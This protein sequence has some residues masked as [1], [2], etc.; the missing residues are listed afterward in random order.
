MPVKQRQTGMSVLLKTTVI[1]SP[2][3]RGRSIVAQQSATEEMG[4]IRTVSR[5]VGTDNGQ[6]WVSTWSFLGDEMD[7]LL[8]SNPAINHSAIV[9]CPYGV[10]AD[11]GV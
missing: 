11:R 9:K 10:S 2:V 3:L 4:R 7:L 8:L 5:P 6:P 1:D